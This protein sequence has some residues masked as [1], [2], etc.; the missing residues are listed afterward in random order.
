[1]CL[2]IQVK[3]PRLVVPSYALAFGYCAS[4]AIF[5]GYRK[6]NDHSDTSTASKKGVEVTAGNKSGV[7]MQTKVAVATI[8]TLVWQSELFLILIHSSCVPSFSA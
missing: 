4:D 8:D 3:A 7:S 5:A 6:W 2:L 1:M